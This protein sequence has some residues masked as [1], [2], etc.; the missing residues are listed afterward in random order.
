MMDGQW[1]W[2]RDWCQ[3]FMVYAPLYVPNLI[4]R[5]HLALETG[6]ALHGSPGR[7]DLGTD[8]RE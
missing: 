4:H 3:E 2:R 5:Q 1:W 6:G 8:D 7:N